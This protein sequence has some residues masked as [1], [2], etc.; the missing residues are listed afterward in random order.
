[1]PLGV[2]LHR[3]GEESARLRGRMCVGLNFRTW[4]LP[5]CRRK[6]VCDCA[7][8]RSQRLG[9]F[10]LDPTEQARLVLPKIGRIR[11]HRAA[12]HPNYLLVYERSELVPCRFEHHLAARCVP[13]IP[14]G[15]ADKRMLERHRDE[16]AIE[17]DS[18]FLG[19][20]HVRIF[21][22]HVLTGPILISIRTTTICPT[23]WM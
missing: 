10:A 18:R 8:L 3:E 7:D 2:H 20:L 11:Q 9:L 21:R 17:F 6:L 4:D 22:F 1:T 5:H 13:T 16:A 15:V 19:V 12:F 23:L 14:G